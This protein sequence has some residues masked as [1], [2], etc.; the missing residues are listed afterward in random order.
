MSRRLA[1]ALALA[2]AGHS[3]ANAQQN[4]P[5]ARDAQILDLQRRLEALERERAA[6]AAVDATAPEEAARALE[7]TLSR[8]GALVLPNGSYELEPR[9][10]YTHRGSRGLDIVN[11]NGTLQVA[12]VDAKQDR[13]EASLGL[14]SGL[15]QRWQA[16]FR[17]PYVVVRDDR[18]LGDQV[19]NTVHDHGLGDAELAVTRQLT[20]GSADKAVALA[21]LLVRFPTGRFALSQA[22][23]GRGFYTFQPALTLVKRDD[24]VVF[25]ASVSY[26]W[27]PPRRHEGHDIDPGDAVGMKLAA[28]LAASPQTSLRAGFELSRAGRT[29]IDG[30]HTPGSDLSVAS[31]QLG[32]S[33]LVS[34]RTL[35]DVQFSAGLTPDSP[36]YA[37]T[38]ALPVR[39]H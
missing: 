8:E 9:F 28:L 13:F 11:V 17:A 12:K 14:R 26:A 1:A 36:R 27:T 4:P 3:A 37:I 24:P 30:T 5:D 33:T 15:G 29:S 39:F 20:Q 7:R 2:L 31:L 6:T 25:L 23:P 16:E 21:S 19:A 38:A 32:M 34:V 10:D 35:L 22:S 18:S